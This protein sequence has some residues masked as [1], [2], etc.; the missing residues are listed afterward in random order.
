MSNN[1][2]WSVKGLIA[3]IVVVG[4]LALVSLGSYK[5]GR[6]SAETS[7]KESPVTIDETAVADNKDHP[8]NDSI[9]KDDQESEAPPK[10]SG[11]GHM[12]Q[13]PQSEPPSPT[14]VPTE[15]PSSQKSTS[16]ESIE[17]G[18]EDLELIIEVWDIIGQE[19]DGDLPTDAEVTY[20]AINGSLAILNDEFTRFIPPEL[21]E[22]A[23]E[24]LEGS[25]EGIGAYVDLNED[26]YLVII[27]PI[28]GQPADL[29]GIQS[30]D[31]ITQVDGES[32]LGKTLDEIIAEVKGPKGT[33]V[34][35]TIRRDATDESFDLTVKRDLIEIM[36]VESK[37]LDD[38][39][40]YI[41]LSSFSSSAE[42]Q[43]AVALNELLA[44]DPKALIFDLRD[45]PGGFLNQSVAVA[46]LFLKDGIV[47][48]ERNQGGVEQVFESD[49]GDIGEQVPLVV[50]VN[51]GS[52]SASEIVAGAIQDQARGMLIGESTF[53]KGSVQQTHVLS[54]GSEL[55]V[56]IARWYTPDNL[57]I[58]EQ[59]ITPDINV[60][61][62]SEFGG[63]SDIQLQRAIEYILTEK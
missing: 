56:T 8:V 39:I 25:F 59:G 43:L 9:I 27:R 23:R 11:P 31:I 2:F 32:V 50:L 13:L 46:D 54:D 21:A 34:K 47:L 61:T 20:S 35:L 29:A 51:S 63:D 36:I 22:R 3:V 49:D 57:S 26:G 62:P 6:N 48:Y 37:L 17:L 53:G 12:E 14:F 5:A 41:R 60:D 58:D 55:R 52:A 1:K 19:Y 40:A 44:Q 42:D 4:I 15:E 16:M 10:L 18:V 28:E 38:D 7:S 45:N 24:Q 30:G 33:E